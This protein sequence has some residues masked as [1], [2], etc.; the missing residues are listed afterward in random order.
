LSINV[1]SRPSNFRLNCMRGSNTFREAFYSAVDRIMLVL[2]RSATRSL[3]YHLEKTFKIKRSDWYRD[4][5][6]FA[7][8]LEKIFGRSAAEY[9]LKAIIRK[10]YSSLGMNLEEAGDFQFEQYVRRLKLLHV[11]RRAA[12]GNLTDEKGRGEG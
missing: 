6:G 9:L 12:G 5:Q 4:P 2:G 10:L 11:V 3:Y 1:N 8:A 7:A